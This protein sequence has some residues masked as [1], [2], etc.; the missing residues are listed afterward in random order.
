MAALPEQPASSGRTGGPPRVL[1]LA[2]SLPDRLPVLVL[3]LGLAALASVLAGQFRPWVVLPLAVLLAGASWRLVPTPPPASKAHLAASAAV[4]ALAVAWT[5]LGLRSVAE[6]VVVNRDP[7][8]LTLQALWLTDHRAAPVPVGAA[9]VAAAAASAASAGTEAFWLQDGALHAQGNKMLPA[10]LAVQGWVG[11]ER[12]VLGGNV[13]I[14]AVALL[15][16]FAAARRFAGPLWALV[17]TAALA[18]RAC[19]C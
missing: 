2:L 6:Y 3:A 9:E 12:A 19:R 15:A 5:A 7:G 17:P 14:G 16:L 1:A 18:L 8:F 4:S 13:V 10:L 11:G